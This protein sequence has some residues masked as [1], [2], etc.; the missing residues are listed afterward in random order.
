MTLFFFFFF[1][2]A[3]CLKFDAYSKDGTKNWEDVFQIS[4][5][6]S[7]RVMKKYGKSALMQTLQVLATLQHVD[8]QRVF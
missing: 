5:P 7:L 4:F 3:K 8:C 6:Q 2:F 1:F